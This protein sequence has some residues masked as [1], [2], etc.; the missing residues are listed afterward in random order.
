MKY[1][2]ERIEGGTSFVISGGLTY[3]EASAF[4]K[5]LER[6]E[7]DGAKRIEVC[8]SGVEAMDSSG[9]LLFVRLHDLSNGMG[10]RVIVRGVRGVVK[11]A[12]DRVS[13]HE[14]V[15]VR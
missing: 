13:M 4:P 1:S 8:V 9:L 2:I 10:G 15:D 11:D 6:L 3:Q 14:L 5:A 7:R 12:F